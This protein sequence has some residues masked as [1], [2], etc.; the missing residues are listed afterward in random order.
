MHSDFFRGGEAVD[1]DAK[2]SGSVLGTVKI[3]R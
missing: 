2:R 1:A 3:V